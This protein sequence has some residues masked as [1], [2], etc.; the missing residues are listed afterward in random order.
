MINLSA[1]GPWIRDEK[2][3]A[4]QRLRAVEE[5]KKQREDFPKGGEHSAYERASEKAKLPNF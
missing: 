3:L 5:S 1:R 2:T 4:V